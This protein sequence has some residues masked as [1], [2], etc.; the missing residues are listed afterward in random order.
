LAIKLLYTVI[1]AP[2]DV[3]TIDNL[4]NITISGNDLIIAAG[5]IK[6]TIQSVDIA[7]LWLEEAR[8]FKGG[9]KH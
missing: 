1:T 8:Q 5:G 3:W 2:E 4:E 7:K 6:T 9:I